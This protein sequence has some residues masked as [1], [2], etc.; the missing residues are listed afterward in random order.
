M[1]QFYF[2][3]A[4]N[5]TTNRLPEKTKTKTLIINENFVNKSVIMESLQRNFE[6]KSIKS[7][8]NF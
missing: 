4:G 2:S 3:A 6:I 1:N 5:L 7:F 8:K